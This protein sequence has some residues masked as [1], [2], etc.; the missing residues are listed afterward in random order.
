MSSSRDNR[1][2][3]EEEEQEQEEEDYMSNKFLE[4][5]QVQTNIRLMNKDHRSKFDCFH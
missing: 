5:M 1:R 3:Q 4:Q 2:K